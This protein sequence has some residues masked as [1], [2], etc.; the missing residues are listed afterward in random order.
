MIIKITKFVPSVL[1]AV[2]AFGY[3]FGVFAQDKSLAQLQADLVSP[4]VAEVE[5]ESRIR[6]LRIKSSAVKAEETLLLE[7]TYRFSDAGQTPI[8]V[9]VMRAGK[10]VQMVFTSQLASKAD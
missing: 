3:A 6:T 8:A 4:W 10:D 9:S 7:A 5:G 2:F 1:L